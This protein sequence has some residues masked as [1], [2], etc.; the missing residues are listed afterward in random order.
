MRDPSTTHGTVI[1]HFCMARRQGV[2]MDLQEVGCGGMDYWIELAE[3]RD[4]W[5]ALVNAVVNLQVPLNAG[6]S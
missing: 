1:T 2:K 6:I 5:W 3:D 4:R